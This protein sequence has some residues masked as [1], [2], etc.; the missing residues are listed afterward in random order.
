MAEARERVVIEVE[1]DADIS[2]DLAAIERRLKALEER[3][4]ALNRATRGAAGANRDFDATS[5]RVDK[6]VTSKTRRFERFRKVMDRT[7]N[8]LKKL[9][10]ALQKF[11]TTF[12]KLSFI[13]IAAE[14]A[15]FTAGF[16]GL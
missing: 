14:I 16:F 2:N 11:L 10:G 9:T 6:A 8:G 7:M 1:I 12:A 3:Q 4:N 13:A 15:V 5:R